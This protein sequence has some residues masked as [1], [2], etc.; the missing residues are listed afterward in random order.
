M[1]V[2]KH[3]IHNALLS[4]RL[5]EFYYAAVLEHFEQF[6]LSHGCFAHY[7]VLLSLLELFDGHNFFVVIAAA[8]EHHSICALSNYPQNIVLLH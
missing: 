2:F 7:F 8:L 4:E 3:Q 6:D 5:L 1:H